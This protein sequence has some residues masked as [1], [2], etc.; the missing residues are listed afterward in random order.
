M[1]RLIA[2]VAFA[3]T[4]IA[5]RLVLGQEANPAFWF[6]MPL[7]GQIAECSKHGEEMRGRLKGALL[8]AK[9]TSDSVLPSE[10]WALLEGAILST[11]NESAPPEVKR[12]CDAL[13][14]Q[15]RSPQFTTRFR[16][17][18]ATQL[19]SSD[20]LRCIVQQP[21]TTTQVKTAWLKGFARNNFELSEEAVDSLAASMVQPLNGRSPPRIEECEQIAR[22]LDS[23]EFDAQYSEAGV[24]KLFEGRK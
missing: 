4:A 19:V 22:Y 21:S 3:L 18:L 2:T 7:F 1:K 12:A 23:S 11:A 15:Y 8:V 10:T 9:K 6:L 24:R 14:E 16:Q 20:S 13:I 5:P 17:F